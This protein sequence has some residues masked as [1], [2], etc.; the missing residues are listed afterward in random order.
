MLETR[1]FI[2]NG[3]YDD[4]CASNYIIDKQANPESSIIVKS[5]FTDFSLRSR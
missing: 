1:Q 5:P 2:L 4:I 3:V